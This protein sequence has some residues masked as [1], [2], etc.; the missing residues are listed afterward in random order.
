[1]YTHNEANRGKVVC[2]LDNCINCRG[3]SISNG[4]KVKFKV[5]PVL[6]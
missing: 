5:V 6:N 3:Y 1:M 4:K 2:V